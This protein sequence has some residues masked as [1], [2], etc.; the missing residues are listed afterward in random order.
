MSEHECNGCQEYQ[1][2]SRRNFMATSGATAI[3]AMTIPAW[4]PRVAVAKDYRSTLRDTVIQIYLRGASD[5]LSMCVPYADNGYY[6][7]RP[8]LAVSR[9]DQTSDPNRA[10]DL[11]GFFGLPP[12]MLPLIP[13]Y[14][15]GRLMFVHATGSTDPTRSHFDAQR[16]ME[17][18]KARDLNLNTGWL[19]RH[20]AT[21]APMVAGASLRGVSI[22]TGLPKTLDGGPQT[23]P[24]PNLDTFGL[25]GTSS[26]TAARQTAIND[27]YSQTTDPVRAAG[28]NT[29]NTINLLN[30]INFSGYVPGGSAVYPNNS[31]GN[32]MKSVAALLKAQ[33]GV[34]AVAID[35]GGWD[36]HVNQGIHLGTMFNLMNNLSN[37]LAAFH[38]DM[39]A[40]TNP[41]FTLVVMSEFGRRLTENGS[42]GTDHGHANSMILMGNCIQGGRVL[43]NWPGLAQNQLFEG[44]DL[45]VTIDYR[46]ILAE[47]VQN[48]LGNPDLA[49]V[50]PTYTPTMRGLYSC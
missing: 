29:I 24:I 17:V 45:Q 38:S 5:G 35:Y 10:T 22:S 47:I 46:D 30:Q 49:T 26:S 6:A 37:T 39:F 31:L 50:F 1:Q 34:E 20:L 16:F 18:G 7:A 36:T 48:R 23:L 40:A 19:G 11:N 28:L 21:T 27:M 4:M 15:A 32:A 33:V 41:S 44:L 25:L 42:N 9:P 14:Q 3:A 2:L 12:A 43:A 8:N 13:A